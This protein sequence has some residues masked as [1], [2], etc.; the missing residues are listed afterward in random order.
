MTE[1][2]D[3]P[4]CTLY[5][6][7]AEVAGIRT[8]VFLCISYLVCADKTKLITE[9]L[10]LKKKKFRGFIAEPVVKNKEKKSSDSGLFNNLK[11]FTIFFSTAWGIL[12]MR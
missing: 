5:I 6:I 12:W 3:L 2:Y 9:V 7:L 10:E 1:L 11:K 4:Q 8:L